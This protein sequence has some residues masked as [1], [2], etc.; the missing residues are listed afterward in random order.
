M[1]RTVL[2][3]AVLGGESIPAAQSRARSAHPY[4]YLCLEYVEGGSL[5]EIIVRR[6]GLPVSKL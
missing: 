3:P 1:L 5:L 4:L 6:T 2:T